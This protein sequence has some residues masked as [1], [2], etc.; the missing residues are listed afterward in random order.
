MARRDGDDDD[1][2]DDGVCTAC[3]YVCACMCL[4]RRAEMVRGTQL[5]CNLCESR[6]YGS[7]TR[8]PARNWMCSGAFSVESARRR[9]AHGAHTWPSTLHS[10]R[11]TENIA[12]AVTATAK[13]FRLKFFSSIHNARLRNIF[14]RIPQNAHTHTHNAQV[15]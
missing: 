14:H 3:V 8:R 10:L 2:G 11:R 1:N 9:T 4:R 15:K 5:S 12:A 7:N 13:P 6:R